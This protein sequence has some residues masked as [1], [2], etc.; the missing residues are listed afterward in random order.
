M[1]GGTPFNSILQFALC[2]FS[3]RDPFGTFFI[4]TLNPLNH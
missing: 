3:R 4:D 2:I 1:N